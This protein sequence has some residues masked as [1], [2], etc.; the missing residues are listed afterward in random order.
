MSAKARSGATDRDMPLRRPQRPQLINRDPPVTRAQ[1]QIVTNLTD[2]GRPNAVLVQ[3]APQAV[4]VVSF[5]D[6]GGAV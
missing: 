5:H 1:H 3:A 4:G 6:E 2:L